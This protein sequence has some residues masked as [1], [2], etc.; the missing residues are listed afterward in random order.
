MLRNMLEIV[1][2][3]ELSGMRSIQNIMVSIVSLLGQKAS[4]QELNCIASIDLPENFQTV[5]ETFSKI[6][7][8]DSGK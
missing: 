1:L 6:F 5:V 4:Y 2:T 3:Y 7:E 8:R